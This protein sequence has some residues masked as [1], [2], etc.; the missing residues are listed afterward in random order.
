MK[1]KIPIIDK[2]NQ[3]C[4][5]FLLE[6]PLYL[7]ENKKDLC[8]DLPCIKKNITNSLISTELWLKK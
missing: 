6:R 5:F 3:K 2:K 8:F 7:I 1:T 4:F